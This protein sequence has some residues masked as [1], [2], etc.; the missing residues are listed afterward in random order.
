MSTPEPDVPIERS[1]PEPDD[2]ARELEVPGE[3]E[4]MADQNDPRYGTVDQ[5]KKP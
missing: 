1:L 2:L 4:E 5:E 3:A